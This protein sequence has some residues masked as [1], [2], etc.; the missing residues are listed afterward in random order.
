MAFS[1][2]NFDTSVGLIIDLTLVTGESLLL[3]N[4][5]LNDSAIEEAI[6]NCKITI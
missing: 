1:H 4:G 3:M 5:G 6:T 2:L